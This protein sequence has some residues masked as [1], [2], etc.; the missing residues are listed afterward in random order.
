M[1]NHAGQC[2]CRQPYDEWSYFNPSSAA[3]FAFS[4]VSP[5]T[6]GP[7][8]A[9]H[10]TEHGGIIRW[11][12]CTLSHICPFSVR[13]VICKW[14]TAAAEVCYLKSEKHLSGDA[15][16]SRHAQSPLFAFLLHISLG[17]QM[18]GGGRKNKFREKSII[19]IPYPTPPVWPIGIP[20]DPWP[21]YSVPNLQPGGREQRAIL[22][23]W[24]GCAELRINR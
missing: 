22:S 13:M 14:Q 23:L 3:P 10:N 12:P 19:K 6:P 2:N 8:A 21:P 16:A 20:Q 18:R 11:A 5:G 17:L 7:C 15:A 1:W 9:N 4:P 24:T